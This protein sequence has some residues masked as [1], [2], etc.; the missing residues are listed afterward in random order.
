M[1][2]L[3]VMMINIC[4]PTKFV[5]CKKIIQFLVQD[6]NRNGTIYGT[7]KIEVQENQIVSITL[8]STSDLQ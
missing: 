2:L 3:P 5:Q 4:Y 8:F 1:L 6:F 7:K